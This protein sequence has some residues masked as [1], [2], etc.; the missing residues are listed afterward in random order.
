MTASVSGESPSAGHTHSRPH[1][2]PCTVHSSRCRCSFGPSHL[3]ASSKRVSNATNAA[4]AADA[5]GAAFA[6]SNGELPRVGC[7]STWQLCVSGYRGHAPVRDAGSHR[8]P[9]H[10]RLRRHRLFRYV[11]IVP[12]RRA[13]FAE[14]E[15]MPAF[16]NAKGLRSCRRAHLRHNIVCFYFGERARGG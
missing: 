15:T 6:P 1:P 11:Y 16:R 2:Q 7:R 8:A 14:S 4:V 12:E 10:A 3:F 5:S 9:T 13:T